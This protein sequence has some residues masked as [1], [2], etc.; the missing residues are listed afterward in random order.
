MKKLLVFMLIVVCFIFFPTNVKQIIPSI[1]NGIQH[2]SPSEPVVILP[3]PIVIVAAMKESFRIES[4]SLPLEVFVPESRNMESFGGI[5]GE[6]IFFVAQGEVF[7]GVDLDEL[8]ESDIEVINVDTIKFHLPPAEIFHLVSNPQPNDIP[9]RNK[10]VLAKFDPQ[11]ETKVRIKGC[12][13]LMQRAIS[14]NILETATLNSQNK[15]RIFLKKLGI[16][17]IEFV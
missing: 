12:D 11:L 9:N 14:S 7:A 2:Q 3:D 15:I 1:I 4:T 8:K 16:K 13:L 10:G 6:T 5:F 17:N